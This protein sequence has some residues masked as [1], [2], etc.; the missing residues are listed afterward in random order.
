MSSGEDMWGRLIGV[1]F[2]LVLVGE[3]YL[4]WR[5][6][7]VLALPSLDL[8]PFAAYRTVVAGLA[9]AFGVVVMGAATQRSQAPRT[10][11]RRQPV[12]VWTGPP[13]GTTTAEDSDPFALRPILPPARM[14]ASEPPRPSALMPQDPVEPPILA[15]FPSLAQVEEPAEP[16]AEPPVETSLETLVEIA[17]ATAAPAAGPALFRE[18]M[19][20]AAAARD[21]GRLDDA[22]ELYDGA[23]ALARKALA[24]DP[25]D[26]T[27]Q[28][29]LAE[30][31]TRLGEVHDRVGRLDPALDLHQESLALRR[32]LAAEAPGDPATRRG[33]S[34][35]LERLADSREARGH[36]SRAR[37]LYRERLKLTE[38]MAA[39]APEDPDLGRDVAVT[40][41]RLAELEELLAV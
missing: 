31:L 41:E 12:V 13:A 19:D 3:A 35:A 40:R 9:A 37:D 6:E 25:S 24:T 36:R 26:R 38:A 11:R 10:A 15:P 14:A 23:V 4:L 17:P 28:S 27:A 8:G 16:A 29:D 39:A 30:A 32:R 2:G 5:P 1:L 22:Q 7:A 18:A 33:L 21:A 20:A 34:E